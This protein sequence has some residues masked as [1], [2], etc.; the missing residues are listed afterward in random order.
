MTITENK[1]CAMPTRI[2]N[3]IIAV[4]LSVFVVASLTGLLGQFISAKTI[5]LALIFSLVSSVL[6]FRNISILKCPSKVLLSGIA[7]VAVTAFLDS[8]VF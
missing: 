6:V 1:E 3:L 4:S 5:T 7:F 8:T 2:V